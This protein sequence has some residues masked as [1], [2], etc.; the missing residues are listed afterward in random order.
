MAIIT[1]ARMQ[2]LRGKYNQL[3]K[4]AMLPGEIAIC[5]DHNPVVRTNK[6]YKEILTE[7][8][9]EYFEDKVSDINK[10]ISSANKATE[11][12]NKAINDM[13]TA[14]TENTQRVDNAIAQLETD[15]EQKFEEL[16]TNV[17]NTVRN[18]VSDLDMAK[19]QAISDMETATTKNTQKTNNAIAK[20]EADKR[21]A[22]SDMNTATTE[23]LNNVQTQADTR[24]DSAEQ[25]YNELSDDIQKQITEK[26]GI[27]DTQ[28]SATTTYSSDKIESRL[29]GLSFSIT[30]NG[31]LRVTY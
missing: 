25:K 12:A 13:G 22:I 29:N 8:N 30:D 20:L 26:I 4:E 21:Q 5:D 17:F 11:N 31:I 27:D 23:T 6:G 18:A 1:E 19:E 15:K 9:V 2:Q 10:A 28:A 24:L 7:D 3:N 14:T 16:D